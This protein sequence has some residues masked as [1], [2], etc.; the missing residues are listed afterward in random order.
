MYEKYKE[1]EDNKKTAFGLVLVELVVLYLVFSLM[2]DTGNLG[3]YAMFLLFLIDLVRRVI[4][5]FKKKTVKKLT[6][7]RTKRSK[8]TA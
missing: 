4:N 5:L 2:W 3:Y 1:L 6:N 8:S 7:A